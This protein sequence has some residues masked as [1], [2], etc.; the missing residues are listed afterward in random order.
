MPRAEASQRR[1]SARR[2][3]PIGSTLLS[4]KFRFAQRSPGTLTTIASAPASSVKT[5]AHVETQRAVDL[6][7]LLR[8]ELVTGGF[9]REGVVAACIVAD[10]VVLVSG[11]GRLDVHEVPL[12]P[13]P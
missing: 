3:A 12:F 5:V 1:P 2:T 9:M 4:Q 7:L 8:E 13:E 11:Q 10:V 6:E